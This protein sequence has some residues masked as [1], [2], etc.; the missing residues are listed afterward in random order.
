MWQATNA[1]V[2]QT[3][4]STCQHVFGKYAQLDISGMHTDHADLHFRTLLP[5]PSC[6]LDAVA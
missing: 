4:L 2:C 1:Y 6:C 3:W 5:S